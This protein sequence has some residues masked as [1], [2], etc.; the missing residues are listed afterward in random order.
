MPRVLG[1]CEACFHY[2]GLRP[3]GQGHVLG[4]RDAVTEYSRLLDVADEPPLVTF[5]LHTRVVTK[6]DHIGYAPT[7]S[8]EYRHDRHVRW[9]EVVDFG[10][11]L[12]NHR[13]GDPLL[14][15]QRVMR[16]LWSNGRIE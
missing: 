1:F 7:R 2:F 12:P 10:V 11:Q 4:D 3:K 5:L 15:R 13:F 6:R 16:L 9:A 8:P 14:P